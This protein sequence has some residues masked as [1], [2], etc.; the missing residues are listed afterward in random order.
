[1]AYFNAPYVLPPPRIPNM[2]FHKALY[3]N[4]LG[5]LMYNS[6]SIIDLIDVPT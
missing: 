4:V 6:F 2:K 5:M 3:D 1:M